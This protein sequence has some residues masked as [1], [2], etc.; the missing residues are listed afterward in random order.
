MTRIGSAATDG[1][2]KRGNQLSRASGSAH[3]RAPKVV[4]NASIEH[5]AVQSILQEFEQCAIVV[6]VILSVINR[7]LAT[8]VV[9]FSMREYKPANPI[10]FSTLRHA[11]SEFEVDDDMI[12]ALNLFH[13]NFH[14]AGYAIKEITSDMPNGFDLNWI[15]EAS[16]VLQATASAAYRVVSLVGS[17]PAS[18]DSYKTARLAPATQLTP[19][20]EEVLNGKAPCWIRGRPAFPAWVNER[21]GK[22]CT[23]NSA[24]VL[25]Y[26]GSQ[27][28]VVV[29]NVSRIGVGLSPAPN[30]DVGTAASIKLDFGRT[31]TGSIQWKNAEGAAMKLLVPLPFNDPL[32][33]DA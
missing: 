23:L 31:L 30:C 6:C 9:P 28:N 5:P 8:K 1:F 32:L 15:T 25:T 27:E 20:L 33:S 17:T 13:F 16:A 21:Q 14:K 2:G 19:L 10:L 29:T 24:A 3:N 22:R 11:L 26:Q 12:G 18:Q 4:R 7:P